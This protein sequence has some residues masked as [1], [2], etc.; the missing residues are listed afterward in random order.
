MKAVLEVGNIYKNHG[1]GDYLCRDIFS[2]GNAIM[3]NTKS[4]WEFVAHGVVMYED[5][6]IEWDYST[7]GKFVL[8]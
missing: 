3:R 7:G 5:G 4:G 1:G 6:T 2:I 8:G